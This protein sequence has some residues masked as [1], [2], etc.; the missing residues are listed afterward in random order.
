VMLSLDYPF[1][2][3]PLPSSAWSR[4]GRILTSSG[5]PSR[6]RLAR[7][8]IGGHRPEEENPRCDASKTGKR[9]GVHVAFRATDRAARRRQCRGGVHRVTP[10]LHRGRRGSPVVS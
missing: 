1:A 5:S 7:P 6:A 10:V 3:S 9:E 4:S 2:V 8:D